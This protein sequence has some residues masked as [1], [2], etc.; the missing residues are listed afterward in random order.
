VKRAG[1]LCVVTL[2][3]AGCTTS[4]ASGPGRPQTD[5]VTSTVTRT[6][7][8]PGPHFHPQT[9]HTVAPLP[10]GRPAPA[11]ERD[12]RC[13]YIRTGLDQT[14][15]IGVNLADLEGDRVYRTTVLTRQRP[16]G[17][18]FYFY[19]PPYEAIADIVAR[20]LPDARAAHDAMVLTA[21]TGRELIAERNFAIGLSGI[22]YRTRFFGPDGN[23]DWAFAFSKGRLLVV[24]HT[25]RSD[26][27]AAN[28]TARAVAGKGG[29]MKQTG[30]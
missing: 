3:L 17:C 2:L 18:R 6:R 7:P 29:R 24:V 14:P 15:N 20:R 16:I 4:T 22:L 1:A 25:Q 11:G 12:G 30:P 23:R 5:T 19:A 28:L 13:P 10:P 21:R 26:G 27:G 9:P 8:A